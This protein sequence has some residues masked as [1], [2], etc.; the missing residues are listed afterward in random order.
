MRNYAAR[1]SDNQSASLH[2]DT[3]RL[4]RSP[5]RGEILAETLGGLRHTRTFLEDS[6]ETEELNGKIRELESSK[7]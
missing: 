4:S 6:R 5:F 1:L 2:H 7:I 3:R